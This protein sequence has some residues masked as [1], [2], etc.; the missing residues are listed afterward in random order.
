MKMFGFLRPRQEAEQAPAASAAPAA[1]AEPAPPAFDFQKTLGRDQVTGLPNRPC[2]AH[3]VTA[4]SQ[5]AARMEARLSLV[6]IG[7]EGYAAP[8]YSRKAR[9]EV[10]AGFAAKL[11][12]KLQRAH[13]MLG[14]LGDGQFGILLPFTDGAG[15]DMV[16]RRLRAM[17]QAAAQQAP[18]APPDMELD[19]APP[20]GPDETM[21]EA[22][23]AVPP[24]VVG[25]ATYCG[26]GKL[27]DDAL[28]ATAERALAFALLQHDGERLVR[29]DVA[30]MT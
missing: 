28:L 10:M 25:V 2:F 20:P 27:A 12:D 30:G 1:A 5:L 11:R 4:Q 9:D 26:K 23:P 17:L 3:L 21:P 22:E 29:Y 7:W 18:V 24:L 13:D 14:S 6:I 15:A 16:A 8:S 19:A